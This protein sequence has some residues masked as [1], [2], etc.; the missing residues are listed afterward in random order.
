MHSQSR[1]QGLFT[2]LNLVKPTQIKKYISYYQILQREKK[3]KQIEAENKVKTERKNV[4][5][6]RKIA[7]QRI[8]SELKER[9]EC[10]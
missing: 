8:H 9:S 2:R 6:K 5:K 4:R 1:D 3:N 10:L 7:S